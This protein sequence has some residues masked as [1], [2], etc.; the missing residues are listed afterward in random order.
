MTVVTEHGEQAAD[1]ANALIRNNDPEFK[2]YLSENIPGLVNTYVGAIISCQ[3][4]GPSEEDRAYVREAATKNTELLAKLVEQ[5]R[6][7]ESEE[8]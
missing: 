1:F 6:V 3:M 8:K 5:G 7:S 4:H 2:G